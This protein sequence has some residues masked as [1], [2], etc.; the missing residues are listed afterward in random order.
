MADTLVVTKA[1]QM[2]DLTAV[3]KAASRV[4]HLVATKA[5]W[6]AVKSVASLVDLTVAPK[7]EES[8]GRWETAKGKTS[9]VQ[10]VERSAET[11]VG[12]TADYLAE[13]SV[14]W[15][16]VNLAEPMVGDLAV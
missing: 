4:E 12:M 7:A 13:H 14:A 1:D 6:K 10:M 5:A 15:L 11:M 3:W 16:D 2:A 8:A 9:V